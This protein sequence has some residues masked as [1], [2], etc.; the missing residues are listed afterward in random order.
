MKIAIVHG[1]MHRGSTFHIARMVAD[2]LA[3]GEEDV[4]EFFL[5]KDGPGFCVGCYSCFNQGEEHCGHHAPVQRIV[6]AF[7]RADVIILDSPCYV[8]GVS[9]QMKAFLDHMGYAW[10]SHRPDPS[11][12][13]KTAL[14]ISTAAGAGARAVTKQLKQNLF[15]W[16]VPSVY[17]YP[18]IVAA[19]GWADVK[20]EKKAAIRR[21]T[22]R[23]AAKL[24]RAAGTVKPGWKTRAMF[25]IMRLNQ[26]RNAWNPLDKAHWEEQG[27]LGRK[28]PW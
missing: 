26:K 12:F 16:G 15:Y 21:D 17:Q 2:Q 13:H 9:G 28:R 27:W 23:L 7:W 14:V 18:C 1:Q 22:A 25:A 11:M 8:F 24:G 4:E 10:M 5:P 3:A 20:E 19:A 6:E